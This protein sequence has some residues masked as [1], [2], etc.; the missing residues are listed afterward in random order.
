[1]KRLLIALTA[2]LALTAAHGADIVNNAKAKVDPKNNK[3]SNPVV[4]KPKEPVMTRDE[5][6][7]CMDLRD[8]NDAEVRAVNG[9]VADYKTNTEKLKAEKVELEQR[10]KELDARVTATKEEYETIVKANE[11]FKA[12]ASKLEKADFEAKQK[13]L[14]DR[15]AAFEETRSKVI[16]DNKE[17][18]DRKAAFGAKIDQVND[19]QKSIEDRRD[20]NLDKQDDW[21]AKCGNKKFDV[22]D[23]AAIRKERAAAAPAAA[24]SAPK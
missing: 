3:V 13:E 19:L 16:A 11:E 17:L 14:K 24:A 15:V 5:L 10:T 20:A 22:A 7:A 1:M 18:N 12:G 2:T 6:R 8:S 21:K 9:L 4:A 23:E